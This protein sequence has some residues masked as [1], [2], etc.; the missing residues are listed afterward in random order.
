MQTSS[1]RGRAGGRGAGAAW[2]VRVM[3]ETGQS[4][5]LLLPFVRAADDA[6]SE[7]LLAALVTEHADPI[8]TRI[9]GHK[10]G[11]RRADARARA[12]A[13]DVRAEVLLQLVQRLHN[14][15]AD[16]AA[17]PI[18]D[19]GAYVAAAAYNAC[20]R[21][22]SRKYPQRRRLKNGLRYLL[23][24][25]PGLALWQTGAGAWVA[26]LHE[27]RA[28]ATHSQA[29]S[30]VEGAGGRLQ[31]LR[32]DA[33]AFAR[34][35]DSRPDLS[36]RRN[37]YD[38]LRAVFVWAA[39]PVELD[40]LTGVVAEWW[41]VRDEAVQVEAGGGAREGEE[42]RGVQL[43][44]PRPAPAAEAERRAYLERLWREIAGLPPR[45]RAA[46]LL[47]LRD[48]Q[49]R[50]CVDLWTL[51]GVADAQTVA[52]VLCMSVAEFAELWRELPLDD[53]RIAAHLG[54]TRQQI[55]N[56]RKCARERL[57]RRMKDF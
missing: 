24:H 19:F 41:G 12:E 14:F 26:G 28:G 30:G 25:R 5:P 15:R 10:L 38:L 17:R 45:Q 7:R 53:N 56:L 1:I 55:I 57:T 20:D 8:V 22:V 34:G 42:A 46:L 50:A 23:T 48:E 36:D 9:V 40:L 35:P 3:T 44:D 6:E 4:D 27:W 43:A 37:A 31:Q 47:H 32:A 29:E 33:R 49:G 13:E 21:Y 54:L 51:T 39:E 52:D 18:R 2:A 11:Q 16:H